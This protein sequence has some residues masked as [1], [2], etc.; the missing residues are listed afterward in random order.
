MG[1]GSA[2]PSAERS[3]APA[4]RPAGRQVD[5]KRSAA[6][7]SPRL[8][9]IAKVPDR[10]PAELQTGGISARKPI[11]G[12]YPLRCL[13]RAVVHRYVAAP[14]QRAVVSTLCPKSCGCQPRASNQAWAREVLTTTPSVRRRLSAPSP[15]RRQW[16][17]GCP[18]A[19]KARRACA[20]PAAAQRRVPERRPRRCIPQRGATSGRLSAT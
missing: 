5:V 9:S 17:I 12:N 2:R 18:T 1:S 7:G 14:R 6:N 15:C 3:A 19:G 13:P 8:L 10:P 16:A 11:S 20:G 4:H